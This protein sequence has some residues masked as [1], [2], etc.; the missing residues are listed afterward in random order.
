M[1]TGGERF[2][3]QHLDDQVCGLG[4]VEPAP[5]PIEFE[6]PVKGHMADPA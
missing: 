3:T 1:P 4:S 2:T 6:D 5:R